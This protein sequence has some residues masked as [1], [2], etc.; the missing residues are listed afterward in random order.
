MQEGQSLLLLSVGSLP[1][2]PV[3]ILYP[4]TA[5]CKYIQVYSSVIFLVY[6]CLSIVLLYV[7]PR[8]FDIEEIG[9]L[10]E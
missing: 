2:D 4:L 8:T 5:V 6:E 3:Y 1:T 9:I 10:K 7:L